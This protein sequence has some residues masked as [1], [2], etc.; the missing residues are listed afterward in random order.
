MKTDFPVTRYIQHPTIP[1]I[2]LEISDTLDGY[3]YRL[4]DYNSKALTD[5]AGFATPVH[6]K[7]GDTHIIAITPFFGGETEEFISVEELISLLCT[8]TILNT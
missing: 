6:H 3:R 1:S 7:V 2:W 8:S 5:W 4:R